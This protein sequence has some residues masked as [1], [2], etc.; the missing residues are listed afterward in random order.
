[1]TVLQAAALIVVA[2]AGTAVVVTPEALRQA[3]VLGV[4]GLTLTILFFVF[5]APDVALSEIVVSGVGLPIIVLAAL[6]K[7]RQQDRAREE[8]SEQ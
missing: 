3:L 1:V 2:I 6:R 8:D 7:I 5:Q 4:F